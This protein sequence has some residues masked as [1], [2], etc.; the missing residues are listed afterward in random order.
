MPATTPGIERNVLLVEE[1]AALAIA[2]ESALKK[3]APQHHTHIATS[4]AEARSI[5][6][7]RKPELIIL[8]FDPP[9]PGAI[10]FFEELQ[11][12]LPSSRV[13]VIAAGTSPEIASERGS[14][15]ALQFLE[16]PFELVDFGAAVQALLGPWK[17][18]G[19]SRGTLRDFTLVDVISLLC[20][21]G[22]NV[23]IQ[24]HAKANR[25]G[26]V[27]IH[28][29]HIVHAVTD[30]MEGESALVEMLLWK[31]ARFVEI[32][33]LPGIPQTIRGPWGATLVRALRAA[34]RR[35]PAVIAPAVA[36]PQTPRAVAPTVKTGANVLVI[37]DTE[38]LLIF[39][40]D[41][42]A[43]AEPNLQIT[44]ALTGLHGVKEAERL[45]PDLVLL[46]Y[47][48]PDIKGD[49]VCRRL[50]SNEITA[51]IPIVMMSG[52]VHE[53][54]AAAEK[55]P[56]VVATIAKPFLSEALV[57]LVRQTLKEG[58]PRK[59]PSIPVP[60]KKSHSPEQKSQTAKITEQRAASPSI[61][62]HKSE[63]PSAPSAG[64]V[65]E[66]PAE[67]SK[68]VF[69][70]AREAG[71]PPTV[72]EIMRPEMSMPS[73]PSSEKLSPCPREKWTGVPVLAPNEVLLDLPLDVVSMQFD[74]SFQIGSIRARPASPTVA[75]EIPAL[76]ARTALPLQTAFRLGPIDLDSAARISIVRLVPT[77]QRFQ[78]VATHGAFEIGGVTV[79]PANE[80]ERLQLMSATTSTMTMQLLAALE[81]E[82]VEFS[83]DLEV[84]Q[85]VL[86]CRNR[87]M[88]V[89][90][91]SQSSPTRIG[92]S[93][94]TTIVELD[95][96]GHISELTL[97]PVS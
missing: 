61:G 58:P 70:P 90:L 30:D 63:A 67:Q 49:E 8:D 29:G 42:L 12:T 38:M 53:M 48:L 36:E 44:T 57:A 75:I 52:H 34:K 6:L 91:N 54:T 50:G 82:S 60:Q 2:I 20:F 9:H 41:S 74:A 85:L 7:E 22:S 94:E 37:D 69:A 19:T 21:A 89:T 4:L 51:A 64:P 32:N 46:D 23:M 84:R 59:K 1:Y 40:E 27:Y 11:S 45:R 88:R 16:K 24:V 33:K 72:A 65:K 76:A 5:A 80:R 14:N 77:T 62:A 87:A 18:T 31:E 43:L 97:A 28:K 93:F 68:R 47:S 73:R 3:F 39:V 96:T 95:K 86:R 10:A 71:M 56:N 78:A 13:L 17:E 35:E 81:L 26:Q 66:K 83:A 15:G 92:A 79:V 25:N 55:L